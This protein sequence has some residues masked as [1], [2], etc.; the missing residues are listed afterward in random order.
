MLPRFRIM[1]VSMERLQIRVA[2]ISA[3][4]INVIHFDPVVMLEEQSTAPTATLLRFEQLG[5]S[6]TGTWMPS[7]PATPVHPIPI[8]G[9]AVAL[10]LDMPFDRH[11]TMSV[12]VNGVSAGGRCGKGATGA[13]PMPVPFD[14][15]S[16]SFGGMSSMCPVAELDPDQVIQSCISDLTD[17]SAVVI[18]PAPNFGI[19]LID[20][21]ALG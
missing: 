4:P 12:K 5:Q 13:D 10:N 21:R 1:A 6:R 20:Q 7:L 9:A 3:V 16:D 11:L 15:P 18:G 14:D 17:P 8:V 2:R 19:E